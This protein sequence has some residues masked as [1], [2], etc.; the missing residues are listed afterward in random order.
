M[1]FLVDAN[2]LIAIEPFDAQREASHSIAARFYELL[3]SQGHQLFVHPAVEDDL[4]RASDPV[5]L[6]HNQAALRKYPTLTEAPI[7]PALTSAAGASAVGTNDHRD[8]RLLAA[9]E[10]SSVDY[11]VTEDVG[12]KRRA[13][14]AG[15]SH[16]VVGL[17]EAVSMLEAE[18]RP[19]PDPLPF[20]T[21]L[22]SF[23]I[24]ES[25]TIFDS[26]RVDYPEFDVWM[27]TKVRPDVDGR[28]C[29][30]VL[31]PLGNYR[32]IALVKRQE[33]PPP[34]GLGGSVSKLSTYKVDSSS[35]GL[36]LGEL[37]LKAVFSWCVANR[38]DHLFVEVH[39]HHQAL[40]GFLQDFGFSPMS[41]SDIGEVTL[42]KTFVPDNTGSLS[43]LDY[44][45][46]YGPPALRPTQSVFI[47]PVI[48]RWFDE[49]FP[50]SIGVEFAIQPT[51]LGLEA[52]PQPVGSAIRKAYLSNSRTTLVA[53][54]DLVAFYRSR[55]E[56]GGAG[57][58]YAAGIVESTLRS[59]EAT[60][61]QAYVGARTVYTLRDI[62][63]MCA[64]GAGTLA[65]MFRQDRLLDPVIPLDVLIGQQVLNGPPQSITKVN[66]SEGR[67]WL[68]DQILG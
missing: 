27:A 13:T 21:K 36:K 28:L 9:V 51:L 8:L 50:E 37:L 34:T 59:T 10:R 25:Q 12:L 45:V 64:S 55:P 15:L 68:I 54:G 38:V 16:A 47:V 18:L 35:S 66:S 5:R 39:S 58:I 26:I 6:A 62:A 40:I 60:E 14:R 7:V 41:K 46:L 3:H 52:E 63:E 43:D 30:V 22:E 53:A 33:L 48:P 32:A 56:S 23:E 20:V 4:A 31:D 49:L 57:Y 61:L 1:R 2:V 67:N 42:V 24:D 17:A 19:I 29:W 11:L 65:M 44:H